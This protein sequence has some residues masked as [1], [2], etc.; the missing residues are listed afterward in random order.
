MLGERKE[1]SDSQQVI[2]RSLS[3]EPSIANDN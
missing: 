3:I 1:E 2:I